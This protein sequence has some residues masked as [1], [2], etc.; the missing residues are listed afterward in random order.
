M[1][2]GLVDG[3]SIVVNNSPITLYEIKK[4]SIDFKIPVNKA[5]EA[6]IRKKL[7]EKL[8]KK[9]DLSASDI[10]INDEIEKISSRANLSIVDFENYLA[11]KGIDIEQYK[12]DLTKKIVQRK[13]Y[14]KLVST[15][16][17]RATEQELK[18]YYQR[19]INL[20]SIPQMIEVTQYSSKNKQLLEKLIKNPMLNIDTITRKNKVLKTKNLNPKLFYI[21]QQT[22]E[23]SF[24]PVLT[25]KD[26]FVCFYIK[27]KINVKPIPFKKV[28]N[29]IFAEIMNK[30]EKD[31]IKSYF[32]KLVSQANIKVLREPR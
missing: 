22:K 23:N 25:L 24:T 10:E 26:G 18:D 21:L 1:I 2:A 5:V 17:K 27:K 29:S 6:L 4:Y 31:I 15:R 32:D 11:K 12:K 20:Y 7:E 19:N 16:I 30:R 28:K 8:I 3:V 9:Y 13:L 14:K